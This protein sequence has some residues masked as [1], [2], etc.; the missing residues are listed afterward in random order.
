M[1]RCCFLLVALVIKLTTSAPVDTEEMN[2][3]APCIS[4]CAQYDQLCSEDE[5]SPVVRSCCHLANSSAETG[6]YLMQGAEGSFAIKKAR[7]DVSTDGGGWTVVQRRLNSSMAFNKSWVEFEEGFGNLTSEFWYGLKALHVMT[8]QGTWEMRVELEYTTGKLDYVHYNHVEVRGPE[9]GY[10]LNLSSEVEEKFRE[11]DFMKLFS[12]MRFSTYDRDNDGTGTI[13][14]AQWQQGGWWYPPSCRADGS[15]NLNA[16]LLNRW[17]S[18]SIQL[19]R[20]EM[21]IRPSNCS[22]TRNTYF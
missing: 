20:T 16:R 10:R 19:A 5:Q 3:T 14:C 12:G 9:D 22:L 11:K 15:F 8:T 4:D 2:S 7:C 6:V 21:K 1:D 13:N 18:S 17:R